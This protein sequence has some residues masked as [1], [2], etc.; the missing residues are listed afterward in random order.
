MIPGIQ[1]A[2]GNTMDAAINSA[3]KGAKSCAC[4]ESKWTRCVPTD[5]SPMIRVSG[6]LV[7]QYIDSARLFQLRRGGR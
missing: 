1:Q 2:R 4:A 6:G 5:S 7:R 3:V